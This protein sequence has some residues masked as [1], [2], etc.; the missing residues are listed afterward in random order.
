MT[1]I[2]DRPEV[3]LSPLPDP[4]RFDAPSFAR[5]WLSVAQA[6]GKDPDLPSLDR[7]VAIE[8][9]PRYGVRLVATDRYMLLTAWVPELGALHLHEP[10]LEEAPERTVV[11]KDLDGRGKGML[12]YVHRVAKRLARDRECSVEDLPVGSVELRLA[13]DI[14]LPVRDGD[15][16]PL[17]GLEPRYTVLEV[18]DT[19]RVYL[20]A[21][22]A[23]YPDWRTISYALQPQTTDNIALHLDRL[24]ALG[25]L[26]HWNAGPLVWTFQGADSAAFVDVK[27]SSPHVSGIVMPVRWVAPGEPQPDTD[28]PS[29]AESLND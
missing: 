8:H 25:A 24:N 26:R 20:D 18:P 14:R 10:T 27:D 29:Q 22:G 3:D 4:I 7:T 1:M 16:V 15:D 19:E 12:A 5:A 21:I 23:V 28:E 9:Y 6:S 17:E 11:T 13:F 2:D